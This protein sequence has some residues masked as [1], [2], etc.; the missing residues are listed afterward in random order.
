MPVS[1]HVHVGP[2]GPK[3]IKD[4]Y[5]YSAPTGPNVIMSVHVSAPK[6]PKLIIGIHV[7]V[8]RS[9]P[10][11]GYQCQGDYRSQAYHRYT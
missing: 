5:I 9:F 6:G 1:I 2:K 3:V 10:D 4:I 8:Y 7:S 11:N